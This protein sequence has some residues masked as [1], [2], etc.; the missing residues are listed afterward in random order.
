M[1]DHRWDPSQYLRFGDE[2]TR[3]FLDLI[4]R[5]PGTARTIVDLGCGAGNDVPP[6]RAR[7]PQARIH[8]VDSSVE[9]IDRARA[10]IDDPE[11]TFEVADAAAW[12]PAGERPDVIVSN[13]MFQWVDG[14]IDALAAIADRAARAFAF[15][16]PG[17]QNA[18]SH[19]LLAQV[20]A[21][22]GVTGYRHVD[23]RDPAEYLAV[24]QRPGW[25][26]D[27]WETTYLHVLQGPD[28]VFEWISG[29]GARP[30][31]ARLD[32]ATK[33]DFVRRYKA[34]LAAAYPP[35]EFGTVLPFRRIFAVAVRM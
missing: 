25:T 11:A 13:A 17:N 18:P 1:T 2:R 28:A 20:A 31:L 7:W 12:R 10:D 6:L 16:V 32:G 24:L 3:P 4:A 5:I 26:V 23:V 35:Q 21:E 19:A 33:D 8:G 34:A 29:T 14:H 22:F 30:V 9:M 15:Q 27:A